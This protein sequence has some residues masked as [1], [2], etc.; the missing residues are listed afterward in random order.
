MV[1]SLPAINEFRFMFDQLLPSSLIVTSGVAAAASPALNWP[2]VLTC[3]DDTPSTVLIFRKLSMVLP[4]SPCNRSRR[5]IRSPSL[6]LKSL[7]TSVPVSPD[8]QTKVS[9]P[10]DRQRVV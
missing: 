10:R 6:A 9:P 3:S 7:I 2:E 1:G 4:V 5:S 8:F